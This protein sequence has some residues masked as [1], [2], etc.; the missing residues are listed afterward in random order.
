M[1]QINRLSKGV[2]DVRHRS[3]K[4]GRG[5]LNSLAAIQKWQKE[6]NLKRKSVK[7]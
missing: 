4:W 3:I 2:R 6:D 7:R 5:S 1:R